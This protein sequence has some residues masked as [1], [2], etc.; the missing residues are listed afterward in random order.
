MIL[1]TTPAHGQSASRL[2]EHT[3][4]TIKSAVRNKSDIVAHLDPARQNIFTLTP[5]MNSDQKP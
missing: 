1:S 4:L 5:P 3:Q 2:N